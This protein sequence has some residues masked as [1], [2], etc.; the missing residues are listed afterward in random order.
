MGLW[1]ASASPKG[2]QIPEGSLC[3]RG[4]L[5][6]RAGSHSVGQSEQECLGFLLQQKTE[7]VK[8]EIAGAWKAIFLSIQI[9]NCVEFGLKTSPRKNE[10]YFL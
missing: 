7:R 1:G 9:L 6:N 10:D 8:K 3:P 2:S 5:K 4:K